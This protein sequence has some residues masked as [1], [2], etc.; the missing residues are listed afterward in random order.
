MRVYS[1]INQ[2]KAMID[3]L[4][5]LEANGHLEY[6]HQ[7]TMSVLG[8]LLDQQEAS[9]TLYRAVENNT[10]SQLTAEMLGDLI[11]AN[12]TSIE[13]HSWILSIET[14][15]VM[16][17]VVSAAVNNRQSIQAITQLIHEIRDQR[18]A[19]LESGGFHNEDDETAWINTVRDSKQLSLHVIH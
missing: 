7:Y 10:D 8:D 16:L 17:Y 13:K 18:L 11:T 9:D 12:L 3:E 1:I 5:K 19:L 14:K 15:T 6:A 2:L 4:R